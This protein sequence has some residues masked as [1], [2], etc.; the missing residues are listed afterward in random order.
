MNP[1]SPDSDN[2]HSQQPD[3]APVEDLDLPVA[4][5]RRWNDK[6]VSPLENL[7]RRYTDQLS[8]DIEQLEAEKTRLQGEI[9][10]LKQNY[11]QLQAE[12]QQSTDSAIA[13]SATD[14]STETAIEKPLLGAAPPSNH[15]V[16]DNDTVEKVPAV[17]SVSMTDR[18]PRLPGEKEIPLPSMLTSPPRRSA[19]VPPAERRVELP[20]PA[21]SQRRRQQQP[22]RKKSVVPIANTTVRRGLILSA[23]ATLITAW[24][25]GLVSTLHQGGSWF[26]LDIGQL[27]T[28]FVPAVALLWLRM[29]VIV[30]T[31]VLL[32][33]QLHRTTWE[34]LLDW[35]YSPE[36]LQ[37][38]LFV[39][40]VGS[41]VA[42]FFSQ[43]FLYQSIGAIGPAIG[44]A[45][46]FLYPLSAIPL[47]LGL[48]QDK[49]LTPFGLLAGVAIAMGGLLVAK[50]TFTT[51]PT[52]V[53]L[54]ILASLT[55]SFYVVLTNRCYRLGCHPI[56]T[57]IVQFSTVAVLSS[58]VLLVKPLKLI[59]ISWLSFCLWGLLIGVLMLIAYLFTYASLLNIRSK[60]AIVAAATPAV[61]LILGLG[62]SPQPTLQI[63]QW[64]GIM[65]VTIGGI[66]LGKEKLAKE[67]D[68]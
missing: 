39:P 5:N 25:Y 66:A 34:D 42:L 23:I 21:T 4:H 31:I 68:A 20:T 15:V 43:V 16:E 9:A 22:R 51:S 11:G 61:A 33:P 50:P 52:A 47:G 37:K 49:A 38:Q 28:G 17:E 26:G 7:Q 63:I 57:G 48:K 45:L 32:A 67:K 55:L 64:T 24:H 10:A 35:F 62:F 54:G 1:V 60:T 65:L 2:E 14:S 30:P 59:N 13:S 44:T 29:V 18:G 56:P 3:P 12:F 6:P 19:S 41:G 27:G 53:G 8:N 58:L 40:L 46:L 36:Q